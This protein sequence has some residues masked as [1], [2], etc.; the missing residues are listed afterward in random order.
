MRRHVIDLDAAI[1]QQLHDL[2]VGQGVPLVPAHRHRD[3]LTREQYPGGAHGA[4]PVFT[5]LDQP[6]RAAEGSSVQQTPC[7][8]VKVVSMIRCK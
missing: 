7:E 4:D 8:S 5:S 3:H 6:P 2:A 1:G